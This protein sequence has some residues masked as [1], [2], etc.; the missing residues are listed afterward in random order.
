MSNRTRTTTGLYPSVQLRPTHAVSD[1][2]ELLEQ[3]AMINAAAEGRISPGNLAML[4]KTMTT[5]EIPADKAD[6][7]IDD[8]LDGRSDDFA[9]TR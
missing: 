5:I 1:T 2:I 3:R 4:N 6:Y 8:A 9:P 7:S